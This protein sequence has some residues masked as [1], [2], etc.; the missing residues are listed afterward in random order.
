MSSF[1]VSSQE[2]RSK[3]SQLEQLNAQFKSSVEALSSSEASLATMWEGEAQKAFRKAFSDD[4]GQFD[5]F[6]A[7]IAQYIQALLNAAQQYETAEAKNVS[8]AS[9]R[10]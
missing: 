2:L 5:K 9:T 3:A 8:T 7:G 1:R 10:K 4:K 6:S